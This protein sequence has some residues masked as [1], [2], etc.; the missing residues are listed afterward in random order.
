LRETGGYRFEL[1]GGDWADPTAIVEV[2]PPDGV[3]TQLVRPTWVPSTCVELAEWVEG[4]NKSIDALAKDLD[5]TPRTIRRALR[6][7]AEED[8]PLPLGIRDAL[9]A[10]LWGGGVDI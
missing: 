6:N 9:T 4:S 10:Y 5:V 7:A 8:R 3:Q 1:S 2:W